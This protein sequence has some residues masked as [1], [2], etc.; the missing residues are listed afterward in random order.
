MSTHAKPNAP[1]PTKA[2]RWQFEPSWS[3][4]G[5]KLAITGNRHPLPVILDRDLHDAWKDKQT[6]FMVK[7]D[8]TGLQ[9]LVD[10]AGPYALVS[11]VITRWIGSGLYTGN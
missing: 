8:G 1:L 5:D 2:L 11:S 9:Q 7:R 6:I 10:E 4:S 3:A